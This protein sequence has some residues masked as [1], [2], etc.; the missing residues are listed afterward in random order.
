M[1]WVIAVMGSAGLI[2]MVAGA[3][4]R[5]GSGLEN[6]VDPYIPGHQRRDVMR[7]PTGGR[8][9]GPLWRLIAPLIPGRDP[10]LEERLAAAGSDLGPADFRLEQ[11][12]WAMGG[13]LATVAFGALALAVGVAVDLRA[14]PMLAGIAMSVGFLGR[15]RM[16]T[17]S[18]D[19][20]RRR[21]VEE[22]PV[23]I[24]LLTLSIMSGESVGSA[25]SR[26][27]GVLG[28]GIGDE[29]GSVVADMR[30]GSPV[31]EAIEGL[32]RRIP[33]PAA[34]AIGRCLVHGR[35]ARSASGRCSPSS[36]RGRARSAAP[37]PH[38]DGWPA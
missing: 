18:I 16:L 20:R 2:L 14:M 12:T 33:D 31:I 9:T 30:A 5:S 25:C 7:V 38:G 26:V 27:A 3:T 32:G 28:E 8:R 10:E 37:I 24:D 11:I 19:T 22:L 1:S 36:S 35:R 23:A 13:L 15:D 6:R 21:L 29:F 34:S 17:R 4:A